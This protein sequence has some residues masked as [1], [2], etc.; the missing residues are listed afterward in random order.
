[1]IFQINV[2]LGGFA[3]IAGMRALP[4]R[5]GGPDLTGAILASAGMGLLIYPLVQG[6]ECGW[7]AWILSVRG[8]AILVLA[9]FVWLQQ[10]A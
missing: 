9:G 7:P 4:G 6:R 10:R 3:L 5:S 8:A 2:P 1:M